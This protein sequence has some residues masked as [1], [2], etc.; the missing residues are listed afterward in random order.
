[1]EQFASEELIEEVSGW[2]IQDVPD[3]IRV[4]DSD[5]LRYLANISEKRKW[6]RKAKAESLRRSIQKRVDEIVEARENQD[7]ELIS[8]LM[9]AFPEDLKL[10]TDNL[11]TTQQQVWINKAALAARGKNDEIA[12]NEPI[13]YFITIDFEHVKIGHTT[14]ITSRLRSLRTA[15]HREPVILLTMLGSRDDERELHRRFS[16][17]R[18][19]REWFKLSGAVGEHIAG[20]R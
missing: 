5:R 16:D 6:L 20:L 17:R 9:K 12:T 15:H 4:M 7:E 10:Y 18:V 11:T 3:W 19:G 13:I 14:N 1:M 2:W 8:V